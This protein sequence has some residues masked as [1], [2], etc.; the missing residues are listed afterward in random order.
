[1]PVLVEQNVEGTVTTMMDITDRRKAEDALRKSEEKFA[2]AF[3]G[4]TANML[5]SRVD[6]GVIVD[7][8]DA[9]LGLTGYSREEL[10]G[11]STLKLGF[12]RSLDQRDQ[13]ICDLKKYGMARNRE[14][15][16]VGK[17]DKRSITLVSGQ[18][19]TFDGDELMLSSSVDISELK[20]AEE[21][22]RRDEMLLR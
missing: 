19:M 16:L 15:E 7:I 5:L 11:K 2:K 12:W 10:I 17:N 13:F 20:E 8:N 22:A 9:M 1:M 4:N 18:L 3:Y 21:A 14:A 6:D